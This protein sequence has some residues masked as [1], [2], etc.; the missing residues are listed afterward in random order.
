MKLLRAS[1]PS[2]VSIKINVKSESSLIMA[3]PVQMQQILMNLCVNASHA[4]MERGGVLGVELSD[5]SLSAGNEKGDG[6][7]PGLYMKLTVSDT[8]VGIPTEIIDKIFDP[9]FTTKKLGEGTGLGLSVV[10][11][12]VS[13][14]N[15]YITVE[16]EPGKGATFTVYLPKFHEAY[17][18]DKAADD[19]VPSGHERVLF[20][21]DEEPLAE[22]GEDIL[23][24]LGYNVTVKTSSKE[25]LA[26]LK[27]DPSRFDLVITDQ[28]M[29]D[30]TGIELAREILALRPGLPIIMAT[31]FSHIVDADKAKAA[32]IRAFVM[33][34]LTKKEIAR[35][36][37]KVLDEKT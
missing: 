21:D 35:A 31:G 34:P 37:R 26:L 18:E 16:S 2:T 19:T 5:Y 8:G 13:Q 28:T 10:H 24:D 23:S 12:I 11:G 32:G 1:I 15:G 17:F 4:M 6:I 29:P 36:A 3:D 25:A 14:H 27:A 9:F 7:K 22:M 33:K 20:V 30:V